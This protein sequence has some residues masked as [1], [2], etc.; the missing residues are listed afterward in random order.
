MLNLFGTTVAG[1]IKLLGAGVIASLAVLA[2]GITLVYR[3]NASDTLRRQTAINCRQVENLKQAISLVL[4]DA[5]AR[6]LGRTSDPAVQ[7]ALEEY[8]DR[9]VARFSPDSCPNP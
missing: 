8:Y 6:A 1:R 4:L 9:Q 2:L 5:R 7:K 3:A